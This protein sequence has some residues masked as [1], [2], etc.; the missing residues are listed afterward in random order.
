MPKVKI[1]VSYHDKHRLLKSD[2]LTPIQTGS[3]VAKKRFTGMLQDD[4]G[5]NISLKNPKYAELSAQYWAWKNY[6]KLGDPDYIGFMHYRRH[7][8]LANN[9]NPPVLDAP[10]ENCYQIVYVKKMGRTYLQD[11]GLTDE[12]IEREVPQ[13]DCICVKECDFSQIGIANS[14]E[15]YE[16]RIFGSQ[17]KDLT[18]FFELIEHDYPEYMP[19]VKRLQTTPHKYLYNMFIMRRDLFERYNRFLFSVLAK[20]DDKIDTTHYI[21]NYKRVLG[22]LGEFCLSLFVNKL[23][24]ENKWKIKEVKTT[25]CCNTKPPKLLERCWLFLSGRIY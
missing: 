13:Y 7:F 17:L 5:E 18:L 22:Y 10:I 9:F 1:L 23:K 8:I 14:V 12:N 21:P 25:F 3:A 16:K 11:I 19:F 15:D 24:S 6:D 4:D 2:I 20:L